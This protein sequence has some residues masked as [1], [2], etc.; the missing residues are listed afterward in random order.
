M[1]PINIRVNSNLNKFYE[2]FN[3]YF[4]EF[5]GNINLYIKKYYG[6]TELYECSESLDSKNI[7]ILTTPISNCKNKK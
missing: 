7:S 6:E 1:L 4:H 5:K 2:F 3:F